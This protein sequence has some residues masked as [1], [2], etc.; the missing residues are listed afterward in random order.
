M[1]AVGMVLAA[2]R[3]QRSPL[4][5][6]GQD[7]RREGG[8]RVADRLAERHLRG[9]DARLDLPEVARRA[10]GPIREGVPRLEREVRAH[11]DQQRAVHGADRGGVRLAKG[12][13]RDAR[14]LRRVHDA[15]HAELA[16]EAQ[17]PVAK[18]P[19]PLRG[20]ER[21]GPVL[22]RTSTARAARA[23]STPSRTIKGRTGCSTTRRCSARRGSRRR[24]RPTSEFLAQCDTFKSKGILPLAYGDRDGYSTDNWVTYD[25]ASYM[26]PG[27]ISK[28]N[29]GK[30][31][32]SDPKLVKPLSR[33]REV[34]A[35]GVR[36]RRRVDARE[37]R[38]EH[39]LHVGQGRDGADVPVRDQGLR[40]GARE[41]PR[42][43]TAA[44]VRAESWTHR[45]QLVPQLGDPEERRQQGR[46]L[47]VHQDGRRQPRGLRAR[48]DRRRAADQQGRERDGSRI[49]S[50][51]SSCRRRRS[52]R[53][54]CSTASFR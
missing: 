39:V 11:A 47:G 30:M 5:S 19:G 49:R 37:Q 50:R 14:L 24:R 44:A 54:R 7:R 4:R 25:Y 36:Q 13:G 26:A 3:R 41:E 43:R 35:A 27:D 42:H 29:A 51:S 12:A 40:E 31:K 33:A 22:P 45:R 10:Q 21:V 46:R 18:G 32:Y 20:P 23:T 2:R 16:R 53:C 48:D 28:V 6:P 34:Q 52:R 17:R 38:R 15:I 1:L 9:L 8:G